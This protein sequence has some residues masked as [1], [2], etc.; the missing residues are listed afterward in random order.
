MQFE[1]TSFDE[2]DEE[3]TVVCHYEREQKESRTDPFIEDDIEIRE[4][5]LDGE[6]ICHTLSEK[7]IEGFKNGAWDELPDENTLY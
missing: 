2:N 1:Y 4:I 7:E 6:D 3:L 5:L